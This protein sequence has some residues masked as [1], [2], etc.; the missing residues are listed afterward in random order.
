LHIDDIEIL[1]KISQMLGIGK[2]YTYTYTAGV[3]NRNS[4]MFIV[5]N[6]KEIVEVLI[7]IFQEFPLQTSKYFDFIAFSEAV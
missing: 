6:I 2:V 1:H 4:A 3:K 5:W 7:P